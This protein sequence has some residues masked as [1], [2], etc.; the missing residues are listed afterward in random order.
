VASTE[1]ILAVFSRKRIPALFVTEL[2]HALQSRDP[3]G[4]DAAL[5]RLDEDGVVLIAEH[6]VPDPHLEGIDLRIVA[7]V[8]ADRP[9]PEAE[10]A[11]ADAAESLWNKWL[12]SFLS[13]H[14]CQ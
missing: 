6:P 7:P 3:G 8:A 9:K 4:L 10:A 14:R 12:A 5:D 2:S 1:E 13:A 11:A